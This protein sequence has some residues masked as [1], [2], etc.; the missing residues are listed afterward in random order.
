[1][2]G[3]YVIHQGFQIELRLGAVRSQANSVL[4]LVYWANGSPKFFQL[5]P[6]QML[7]MYLKFALGD[8]LPEVH[9]PA[10]RL[11]SVDV[12]DDRRAVLLVVS[13]LADHRHDLRH[14]PVRVHRE[15]N[16]RVRV[17]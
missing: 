9:P 8:E 15:P 10:E 14:I 5:N 3:E 12:A 4:E 13:R 6:F 11:Q 17:E 2:G 1:M 7:C 16:V